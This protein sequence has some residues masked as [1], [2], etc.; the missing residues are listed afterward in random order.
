MSQY[1][2]GGARAG[3]GRKASG[4]RK[5]KRSVSLSARTDALVLSAMQ[6][7]E[8]YSQALERLICARY[9]QE[10]QTHRWGCWWRPSVA[11][12]NRWQRSIAAWDGHARYLSGWCRGIARS[13]G[14]RECGCMWRRRKRHRDGASSTSQLTACATVRSVATARVGEVC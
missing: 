11:G 1:G 9:R 6:A 5:V 13:W 4:E 7:D 12:A 14:V 3:A 2:H 8:T 10:G